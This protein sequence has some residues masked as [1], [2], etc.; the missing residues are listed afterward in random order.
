[1]RTVELYRTWLLR[2]KKSPALAFAETATDD[3]DAEM[4]VEGDTGSL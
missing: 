1:M 3:E 4:E 2:F